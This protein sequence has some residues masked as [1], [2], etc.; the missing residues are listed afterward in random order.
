M[1]EGLRL[2]AIG[3]IHGHADLLAVLLK[4]I[5]RDGTQ[6]PDRQKILIY[7]GDYVDRGAHSRQVIEML[8]LSLPPGFEAIYLKG[9]HEEA[10]LQFLEDAAFGA[11]WKYYGGLETLLS[12]GITGL[13]RADD[14]QAFEQIREDFQAAVPSEHLNFLKTLQLN[15]SFGDYFFVHA[16]VRPGIALERQLGHDMLWIRDEFLEARSSFGKV[17]VHGHTPVD[18]PEFHK[19]RINIDTGAYITNTLTC[20]VL[21][22]TEQALIQA[23]GGEH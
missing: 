2:Y 11:E 19:N 23:S 5:Y 6:I 22:G 15:T 20:L 14:S 3:D 13:T 16:G 21:D 1:P 8:L 9:N 18:A 10:L 7:L 17:I 4:K 12:Y